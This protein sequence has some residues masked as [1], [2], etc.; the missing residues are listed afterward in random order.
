MPNI[1]FNSQ[2]GSLI[3]QA[4]RINSIGMTER[5]ALSVEACQALARDPGGQ[6]ECFWNAD[7]YAYFAEDE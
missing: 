2:A 1:R 3:H 6:R 5:R 4:S 7:S